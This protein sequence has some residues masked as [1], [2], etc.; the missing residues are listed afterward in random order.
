MRGSIAKDEKS[1][2]FYDAYQ[3][4]IQADDNEDFLYLRQDEGDADVEEENENEPPP[5]EI[6]TTALH[7]QLREAARRKKEEG[8]VRFLFH[9]IIRHVG[10]GMVLTLYVMTELSSLRCRRRSL[11]RPGRDER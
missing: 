8:K 6:S 2:P 4:E 7:E 10:R 5:I 9:F 1:R 11:G 3:R